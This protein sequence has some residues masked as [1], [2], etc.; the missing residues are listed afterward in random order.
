[1]KNNDVNYIQIEPTT[2]CNFSCRFCAGRHLPHHDLNFKDYEQI[3]HSFPELKHI[4]LQGEGEPFLHPQF[5]QMIEY[6]RKQLSDVRI[7]SITNGSIL[8]PELVKQVLEVQLHNL[9]FSIDSANPQTF[10]QIRGGNL[11]KIIEHIEKLITCRDQQGLELPTIGM[12]VTIQRKTMHEFLG[13]VELFKKLNLDGRLSIQML[14]KMDNY[15]QFYDEDMKQQV[16]SELEVKEFYEIYMKNI[17]I[18]NVLNR[19]PKSTVF[20]EELFNAVPKETLRCPWL[21][22]GLYVNSLGIACG[23][24]YVKNYKRDGFGHIGNT[25]ISKILENRKIMQKKLISGQMPESCRDCSVAKIILK[26]RHGV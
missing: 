14:Q 17:D 9:D 7:S 4:E 11:K 23:C 26:N 3:I 16:L 19:K 1:M 12:H 8:T 22:I 25:S 21:E 5:I 18:F 13:I 20:Y 15:T 24:C 2:R 6:A 10:H